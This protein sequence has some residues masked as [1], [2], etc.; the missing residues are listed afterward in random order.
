MLKKSLLLYQ[1][2]G[3]YWAIFMNQK[4]VIPLLNH[5]YQEWHK[6]RPYFGLWY[7]EIDN[8]MIVD[9]CQTQQTYL[10]EFLNP[11][12]NRQFHI[13][14]FVNGFWVKD[15]WYNDD[16]D[17]EDLNQQIYLLRS[18]NLNKFNLKLTNFHSFDNCLSIQISDNEYLTSIRKILQSAHNEISPSH[19]IAHITL[20][21][22][23]E[24]F[25]KQ[26]IMEKIQQTPIQTLSFEV[27]K[28]TFGVYHSQELQGKLTPIFNLTL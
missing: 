28:L 19:Y 8:P 26:T 2:L 1:K 4:T 9:Y 17:E 11:N 16:F 24:R 5:D 27:K 3:E 7:I 23:R 25:L 10:K 18:L 12:Y 14:L 21:F 20:G 22:Y 15:K 13:T 6:N